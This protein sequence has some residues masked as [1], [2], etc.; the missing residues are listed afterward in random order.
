LA[1]LTWSN[2]YSVGVH[3][4][5]YQHRRLI[6]ILNGLHAA[7]LKGRAQKI[8]GPLLDNLLEFARQHFSTE[9][10]MMPESGYADLAEHRAKHQ[11]LAGKIDGYVGR[12][13]KGDHSV[14]LPLLIFLR[15]WQ[16]D[17]WQ[18]EDQANGPCLNA[19]GVR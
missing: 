13:R 6:G 4:L 3:V 2:K 10:R 12:Y 11:E 18:K 14:Y 15:D 7:M 8:A 19:H 9:E 16:T 1:L 5:D 17:H